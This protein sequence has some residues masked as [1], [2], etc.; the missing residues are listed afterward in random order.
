MSLSWDFSTRWFATFGGADRRLTEQGRNRGRRYIELHGLDD[1][2]VNES[3][4]VDSNATLPSASSPELPG[5]Q[6]GGSLV[7]GHGVAL[8]RLLSLVF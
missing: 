3:S 7:S 5:G 2:S 1:L 6:G 8:L 4:G